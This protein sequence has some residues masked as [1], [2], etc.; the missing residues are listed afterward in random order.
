MPE[1]VSDEGI[2]QLMA[3][4]VDERGVDRGVEASAAYAVLQLPRPWPP[5]GEKEIF[6]ERTKTHRVSLVAKTDGGF[7]VVVLA[8]HGTQIERHFHPVRIVGGGFTFLCLRWS[9]S[10]V[11]LQLGKSTLVPLETHA[12]GPLEVETG[13]HPPQP[14]PAFIT[15]HPSVIG[16]SDDRFFIQTLLDIRSKLSGDAYDAIKAAGLLRLL[17]MD[18]EPLF[19][20][21]NRA[22]RVKIWF[23]VMDFGPLPIETESSWHSLL[24]P[25]Q[26]PSSKTIDVTMDKFLGLTVLTHERTDVSVRD[27]IS[28]CAHVKGGVHLGSRMTTPERALLDWDKITRFMGRE[29]T[30]AALRDLSTIVL[31]AARPLVHSVGLTQAPEVDSQG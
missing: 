18:D 20:R 12:D 14:P 15:P 28:A 13:D 9:D 8:D 3:A 31:S 26:D 30:V 7:R 21:I 25:W 27:V 22:R 1:G 24:P 19:H 10:D 16:D 23:H 2:E 6:S 29:P 17:L 11:E 4:M 5:A